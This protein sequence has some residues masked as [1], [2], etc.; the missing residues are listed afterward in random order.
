[1]QKHVCALMANI[2][3]VIFWC[4]VVSDILGQHMKERLPVNHGPT[5]HRQFPCAMLA[6][7]D[8]D[9]NGSFKYKRHQHGH[10]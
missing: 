4:N 6:H 7:I 2:A 5:L 8:Q 10:H 1:M 9:N 3:Q